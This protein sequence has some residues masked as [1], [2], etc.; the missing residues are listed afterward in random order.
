M[1]KKASKKGLLLS[2]LLIVLMAIMV[3]ASSA[4]EPGQALRMVI[5]NADFPRSVAEVASMGLDIAS[6]RADKPGIWHAESR[7][8]LQSSRGCGRGAGETAGPSQLQLVRSAGKGRMQ[9]DSDPLI[10]TAMMGPKCE[11]KRN[12]FKAD[13][14]KIAQLKTRA[15]LSRNDHISA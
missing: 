12:I 1:F 5:I 2:L 4:Q 6:V 11:L 14:P 7:T 8:K 13:F 15:I 9:Q 10:I 3:A